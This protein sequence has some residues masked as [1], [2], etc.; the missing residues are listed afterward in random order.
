MLMKNH[1]LI[2]AIACVGLSSSVNADCVSEAMTALPYFDGK[3]LV[4]PLVELGSTPSGEAEF[5][6]TRLELIA[7]SNPASFSLG[8][9]LNSPG[10]DCEFISIPVANFDMNTQQLHIPNLA[11]LKSDDEVIFY[12]ARL[13]LADNQ[14]TLLPESLT[15]SEG[16]YSGVVYNQE[17]QQPLRNGNV[18]LDGVATTTNAAGHFSITGISTDVCQTLTIS[19]EGFAPVVKEVDIRYG[20]QTAC[21]S[22]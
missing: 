1:N 19:G 13:Q 4:M 3:Q 14:L 10:D 21:V 20:G 18:S 15:T 12:S 6:A 17:T 7:D 8:S 2:M 9:T 16:R 5:L 11:W 22:Q